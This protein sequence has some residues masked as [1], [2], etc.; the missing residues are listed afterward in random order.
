MSSAIAATLWTRPAADAVE[1]FAAKELQRYLRQMLGQ[2]VA[3]RPNPQSP[4]CPA[5]FLGLGAGDPPAA[6]PALPEGPSPDAYA[7]KGSRQ[8]AILQAPTARGLLYAAYGLL[9]HLGAR[10]FFPGPTGEVIPRLQAI[11]LDGLDA[12]SAP[13]IAQR[14]VHLRGT[15]RY[16][17][18]WLDFAPK[19]GL[20]AFALE[21]HQGVHRLPALAA[22]RGL[23]LRLRR[24]FFS[25]AFCSQDERM[26]RWQETLMQGYLM[27]LPE[28]V[29]SVHVRPA[30][31]FGA[32]CDCPADAP[33]SV[34]DQVLRFTNR[35]A[36]AAREVRPNMEYPF[37]AYQSTWCPPPTV[38]PGEGVI[39]SLATIHRCFNH[40]VADPDCWINS[41]YKYERP[42][43]RFAYG[44]RPVIEEYLQRFDPATTFIVDYWVDAS[45]FGRQYMHRWQRRLPNYGGM[46]QRDIQY[47][48][49]VGISAIWTFVVF[50][51]DE[52]LQ[53]YRSPLI[54]Q[55]GD[56]LWNPS[57]DLRAG[58]RDFCRCY[59][60]DAE[61]A[62]AFALD[63]LSD[64]RH[65]KPQEWLDQIGRV[66]RALDLT[67]E[68]RASTRDDVYRERLSLLLAEHEHCI[69]AMK[70]Y[71]QDAAEAKVCNE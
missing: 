56:L 13:I 61:L 22:G 52:Y 21:A 25:N 70:G 58:L 62:S 14:G 44:I 40:A 8:G 48:H 4:A 2:E 38:E 66:S 17:V 34:A 16:L 32:H 59:Y 3:L 50:V 51:D 27:S 49:S 23:Y 41:S 54:F 67:R 39:L 11:E 57:A 30:D 68:A 28:E 42:L 46:V 10:W 60:G 63:E 35:M 71:V 19:I 37:V 45:L 26:L 5:I 18:E 55:Y 31:A 69:A 64:P 36:K 33:Y 1:Q 12:A 24:P 53:R 47:Y 9:K 7:L 20:N 6:W 15:D 65:I 29:E 43:G